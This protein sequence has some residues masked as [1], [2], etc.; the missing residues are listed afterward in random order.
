[1][2]MKPN[3]TSQDDATATTA[4]YSH[5]SLW[6]NDVQTLQISSKIQGAGEVKTIVIWMFQHHHYHHH[7]HQ[8]HLNLADSSHAKRSMLLK[9]RKRLQCNQQHIKNFKFQVYI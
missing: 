3:A 1:M 5:C 7:H 4:S 6:R 9:L 2:Q 8:F